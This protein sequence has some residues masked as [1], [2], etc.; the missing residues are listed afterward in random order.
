MADTARILLVEDDTAIGRSLADLL[1]A[2]GHRVEW[3]TTGADALTAAAVLPPDLVLLDLGLPDMDGIDACRALRRRDQRLAIIVLTARAAEMDIVLGLDAGA[4]DYLTKPFRLSEL[5]A[6]VRAH[7]RRAL[8]PEDRP[9]AGA[10][11]VDRV[12]RRAVC[13]GTELHLRPKEYDLLA[14]LVSEADRAVPR[15]RIM[16]EVWG[17]NWFGST[18]TLDTH[19]GWLRQKLAG[20]GAPDVIITLRGIGY[21]LESA[22]ASGSSSVK[23]V[24]GADAS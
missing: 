12:A 14:L 8:Q 17:E 20:A 16:R 5:L 18:K 6:R 21:R 19:I 9:S 22:P 1:R 24:E 15:A 13:G 11:E 4:D 7:L 3:L 23:V 10:I 2:E